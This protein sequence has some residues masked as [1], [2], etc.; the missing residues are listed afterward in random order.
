MAMSFFFNVTGYP[1]WFEPGTLYF[2][3][4]A[5]NEVQPVHNQEEIKW[6]GN[7]FKETT[8]HELKDYRWTNTFPVH[9]RIFSILNPSSQYDKIQ[10]ALDA[11]QKNLLAAVD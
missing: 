2:Y 8:G 3:N 11:I 1:Q 9:V 4:G 6:L 10:K 5:I 7:V